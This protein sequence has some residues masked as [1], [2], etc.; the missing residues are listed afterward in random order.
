ML[1]LL[2]HLK[3]IPVMC[4]VQM[5]MIQLCTSISL[6]TSLLLNCKLS[7]KQSSCL[8]IHRQQMTLAIYVTVLLVESP[9]FVCCFCSL[10]D[11]HLS[12]KTVNEDSYSLRDI[13]H[14]RW[15]WNRILQKDC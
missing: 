2:F 15:K 9:H 7:D 5:H 13:G 1:I 4:V 11:T 6:F 8:F 12:C 10:L 3:T 14:H